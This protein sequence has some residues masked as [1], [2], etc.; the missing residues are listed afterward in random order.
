M[1][2]SHFH[3]TVGLPDTRSAIIMIIGRE[4]REPCREVGDRPGV[5][6]EPGLSFCWWCQKVDC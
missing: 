5:G 3:E 6:P 1:N 4:V 2:N